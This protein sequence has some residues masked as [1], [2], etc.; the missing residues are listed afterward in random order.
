[1]T[2][3]KLL[4]AV[5]VADVP[6]AYHRVG[7]DRLS[8]HELLDAA[9]TVL[10]HP[11]AGPP[12][13]F[14]LHAPLE[15]LARWALLPLVEPSRREAARQRIVW[16]AATY[17]Q[18][19][20]PAG[21]VAPGAFDDLE[22]AAARLTAAIAAGD[23]DDSEAAAAWLGRHADATD[24]ARLVGDA[25][26]PSLAAAAHAGIFL[27][28]LPRVAPRSPLAASMLRA[29]AREL[30]RHPDWTIRWI[31]DFAAP[32]G[33]DGAGADLAGALA[34]TPRADPPAGGSIHALVTCVDES[35]VAAEVV[36]AVTEAVT[37][38]R[39]VRAAT[40]QISRVA[41]WSMLQDD[42]AKAP[43]GWSHC[44]TIPQG[45]AGLAACSTDPR[46][47]VRI[48]AT[49]VA[50]FR[51]S[52]STGPISP[53]TP[54]PAASVTSLATHAA[55]HPDAHL[56]KYTVACL[57]ASRYDP[58]MASTYL[59]AAAHLSGWWIDHPVSDDPILD[60]ATAGAGPVA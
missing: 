55:I 7:L 43:Y 49:H 37:S 21:R 45:V 53:S 31:D 27:H 28:L 52:L 46:R 44:L 6:A 3:A 13:S 29:P 40:R 25:V 54:A 10:S 17:A 50:A 20:A 41:A 48:A 9:A 39:D 57:E 30:A 14:V 60:V 36:G 58:E 11:R 33:P 16:L 42:P 23:L 38:P 34:A 47:I 15:L 22:S 18:S 56:A 26:G 1:M 12:D 19:D 32:S 8:D 4:A 35:G 5:D 24:I 51:A 59:A 2:V